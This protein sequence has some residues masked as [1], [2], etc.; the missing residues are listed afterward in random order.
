MPGRTR[1]EQTWALR[2]GPDKVVTG[3]V[4]EPALITKDDLHFVPCL[5]TINKPLPSVCLA[6]RISAASVLLHTETREGDMA[7]E[8]KSD[9]P[10]SCLR[11]QE[12]PDQILSAWETSRGPR[13]GPT[14]P[15]S[16]HH[17]TLSWVP[18]LLVPLAGLPLAPL[19]ALP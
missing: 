17:Q 8:P 15:T 3:S 6:D 7:A 2:Q 19:V 18:L 11:L 4:E 5:P 16:P 9:D 14:D 10:Q 12:E 1:T 13:G